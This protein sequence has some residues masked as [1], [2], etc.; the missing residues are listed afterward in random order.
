M[1]YFIF[2]YSQQNYHDPHYFYHCHFNLKDH[3]HHSIFE[4]LSKH[5][6]FFPKIICF[7]PLNLLPKNRLGNH[8]KFCSTLP[9]FTIRNLT[10]SYHQNQINLVNNQLLTNLQNCF[11]LNSYF[12][13][14]RILVTYPFRTFHHPLKI[15]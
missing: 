14:N 4:L 13:R 2:F 3:F 8:P 1:L 9:Q 15:I 12:I 5:L 6:L 10:Y 11:F 7:S